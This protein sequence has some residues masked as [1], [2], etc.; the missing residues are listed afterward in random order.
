GVDDIV[1]CGNDLGLDLTQALTISTWLKPHGVD[2][3]GYVAG[4]Y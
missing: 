3:G 1:N 2:E 4:R